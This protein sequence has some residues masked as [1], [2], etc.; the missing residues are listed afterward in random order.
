MAMSSRDR[1][2]TALNHEEPDRVPLFIGATGVTSV[3]GPGYPRLRR[4][5]GVADGPVRLLSRTFQ[6]TW[7]DE[8]VMEKLGSDARPVMPAP[9]LGAAPRHLPGRHGGRLGRHVA[10]AAGDRVLRGG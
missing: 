4:H 3:L 1:V 5:L 9:R 10:A 8:E 7:L 6:Y 2:L